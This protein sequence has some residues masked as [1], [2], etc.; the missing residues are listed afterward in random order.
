MEK[1]SHREQG[2]SDFFEVSKY[3]KVLNT[4]HFNL[5]SFQ[6]LPPGSVVMKADF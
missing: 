1:S 3:E 4:Y 5:L 2:K 6:D